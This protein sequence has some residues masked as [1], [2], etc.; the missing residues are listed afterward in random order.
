MGDFFYMIKNKTIRGAAIYFIGLCLGLV[1][2]S[3]VLI[4]HNQ[5]IIECNPL[6]NNCI[7]EMPIVRT[8]LP[9]LDTGEPIAKRESRVKYYLQ[10]SVKISSKGSSG[11]GTICYY[12]EVTH[13]AYVIS[14]GHLFKGNKKPGEIT[15]DVAVITAFYNNDIKL[16]VPSEFNAEVLCYDNIEDIALLKFTPDWIP[17]RY[18]AIAPLDYEINPGDVFESTGCDLGEEV[19]AYTITL[20]NGTDEGQN[21]ISRN[22]SPR[23]GRSGGGV[24]SGD[25]FYL[26]IVW[27]TTK[28]NGSGY[29]YYVPLRRIRA[30]LAQYP[31]FNEVLNAGDNFRHLN[32]I[33]VVD[34]RGRTIN[35][36]HGYIPSP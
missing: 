20:I 32:N 18:F 3:I 29:G 27:G 22:N 35:T 7:P 15:K 21:L 17:Q 2:C 30:Y 24:L 12:D 13:E 16:E 5:G 8:H 33:P 25:G 14:C 31:Q 4:D 26:A 34:H 6:F 36:P 1:V 19:A 10:N 11:S 9:E 23:P 28:L